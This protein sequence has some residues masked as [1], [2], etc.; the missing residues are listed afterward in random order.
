M[1]LRWCEFN[2]LAPWALRLLK[3]KVHAL[4]W[5]SKLEVSPLYPPP[6][7]RDTS[8][9]PCPWLRTLACNAKALLIFANKA[10]RELSG[11]TSASDTDWP[12]VD[13]N[14]YRIG[15]P[16]LPPTR[17]PPMLATCCQNAFRSLA[18]TSEHHWKT[19]FFKILVDK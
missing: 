7:G 8:A 1:A 16:P 9:D 19:M 12:V 6:Q 11:K 15:Y 10:A 17:P 18:K 4:G 5:R 2:P 13:F 3:A 14:G